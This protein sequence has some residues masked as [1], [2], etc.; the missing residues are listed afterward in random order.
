MGAP[1]QITRK[2]YDAL[3]SLSRNYLS[4]TKFFQTKCLEIGLVWELHAS[5]DPDRV[6]H[7]RRETVTV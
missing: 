7:N 1:V 5:T 3:A 2:K 4:F 6:V